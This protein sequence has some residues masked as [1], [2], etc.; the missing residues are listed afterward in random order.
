MSE[1]SRDKKYWPGGTPKTTSA[2]SIMSFT[3]TPLSSTKIC[4][5]NLTT[6][7]INVI[8][9]KVVQ[10]AIG[11]LSKSAQRSS[12]QGNNLAPASSPSSPFVHTKQLWDFNLTGLPPYQQ[13]NAVAIPITE[14]EML[15]LNELI[16]CLV[17]IAGNYITPSSP[18]KYDPITFTISDQI[19]KSLCDIALQILPLASHYSQI[20]R[21]I[22]YASGINSSPVLQAASGA[23]RTLLKDYYESICQLE[24]ELLKGNLT[25]HKLLYHIRPTMSTMKVL[26]DTIVYIAKKDI[27]GGRVLTVLHDKISSLTGDSPSQKLLIHLTQMAAVPYMEIMQ[28]W[29]LKGVI[30]DPQMEFFVVDNER[31]ERE[32]MPEQHYSADYWE[33][34]YVINREKVPR[35]LEKLSDV[36]LRTGKY[37]NVIRQC[38]KNVVPPIS[39]SIIFSHTDQHY[40]TFINS[41]YSFASRTLLELLM[42]ENDLMG[43]LQSVKRYF[44][45]QQGDFIEQFMDT[46]EQELAKNVDD[47][48]PIRLEN[49]LQVTLRISSAQHDPYN[50]DLK[51]ELLPYD[52]ITQISKII[53]NEEEEYWTVHDKLDLSGLE[54]FA[55]TYDVKWP[56]SLVL[57]HSA[58]SKYQMLFRQLFYCK[59]VERQLNRVWISTN[60]AKKFSSK[61]SE[62]YRSAFTLRQRM[63][64]AIQNLEYY[65]MIEVIEPNWHAFIEKMSR[66]SYL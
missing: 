12:L 20:Q 26:A 43:H 45:L 63:M 53:K 39:T 55:F 17:G 35:F 18:I 9:D 6:S 56:I 48:L 41:A 42:K 29:I 46:C 58:I 1:I 65:M 21:F 64:N 32:E 66:V 62:L 47:V 19:Q 51:T 60:H 36:I 14:Q 54:C 40:V 33:K 10:A 61:T 3:D 11:G 4:D 31:I 37:L 2:P 49:L 7:S 28:L 23:L 27:K 59:H 44:L 52:L 25:L 5:T 38:G 50:D 22:Q 34:R 30:V 8:R 13:T 24:S 16:Y 57:N 15:V